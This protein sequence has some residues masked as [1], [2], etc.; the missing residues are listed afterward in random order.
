MVI[1]CVKTSSFLY[2]EIEIKVTNDNYCKLLKY[3]YEFFLQIIPVILH[4]FEVHCMLVTKSL[5]DYLKTEAFSINGWMTCDFT[6][7]L[8]NSISV[9]SG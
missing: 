2:P 3:I 7:I 1:M 6:K 5:F 9:I 4:I 8:F